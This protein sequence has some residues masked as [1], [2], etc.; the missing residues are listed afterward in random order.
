MASNNNNQGNNYKSP[1]GYTLGDPKNREKIC[2]V[3]S[4]LISPPKD[5]LNVYQ[6]LSNSGTSQ[7][8]SSYVSYSAPKSA[9]MSNSEQTSR[10]QTTPC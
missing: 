1:Y 3:L 6:R 5:N 4:E 8:S 10:G 9:S 7:S 2:A